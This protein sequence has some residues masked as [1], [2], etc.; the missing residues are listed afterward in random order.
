MYHHT[1][2]SHLFPGRETT[3]GASACAARGQYGQRQTWSRCR[4]RKYQNLMFH[5]RLF[6][7]VQR[8]NLSVGLGGSRGEQGKCRFFLFFFFFN[9][10]PIAGTSCASGGWNFSF[11]RHRSNFLEPN[12]GLGSPPTHHSTHHSFGTTINS[13]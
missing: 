2:I 7:K 1:L 9:D 12:Q 13:A 4:Q 8:R 3:R 5:V 6:G 11:F 10:S